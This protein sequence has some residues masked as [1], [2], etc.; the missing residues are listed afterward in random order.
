MIRRFTEHTEARDHY[1]PREVVRLMI[2]LLFICEDYILTKY[3]LTQTLYDC[4]AGTGGMCSVAQEYLH[5]L[6][7][8]VDLEFFAQ[9]LIGK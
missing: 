4:A 5:E 6:N 3:G 2:S 1:T 8:N 7:P 9:E